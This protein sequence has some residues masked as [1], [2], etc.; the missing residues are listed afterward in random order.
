[1]SCA[2]FCNLFRIL[3]DNVMNHHAPEGT[4][5]STQNRVCCC[6]GGFFG[7][8]LILVNEIKHAARVLSRYRDARRTRILRIRPRFTVRVNKCR[9][10][11]GRILRSHPL[12]PFLYFFPSFLEDI[13]LFQKM[14]LFFRRL[15][16]Y[17]SAYA[18]TVCGTV[19]CISS[20]KTQTGSS[21][22]KR[23]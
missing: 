20:S 1:M 2:F 5:W 9:R 23:A 14:F 22:A 18:Y 17:Q 6:P 7:Y 3:Q 19:Y 15:N 4:W 12:H 8:C 11:V 21:H 16:P 10:R 13:F